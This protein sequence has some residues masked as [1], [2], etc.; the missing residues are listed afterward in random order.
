MAPAKGVVGEHVPVV[1]AH[2][3]LP[4]RVRMKVRV[5]GVS[6][7]ET[8][9]GECGFGFGMQ[10]LHTR[11]PVG[12]GL[13]CEQG[14]SRHLDKVTAKAGLVLAGRWQGEGCT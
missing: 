14:G 8:S 4:V 1:R 10:R 11:G 13:W 9:A 2:V 5:G 12:A 7:W 3:H 6:D